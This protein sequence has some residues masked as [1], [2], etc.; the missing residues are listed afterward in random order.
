MQVQGLK[1][2]DEALKEFRP[3]T[4]RGVARRVLMKAGQPIAE[5]A[6]RLAPDDPATG[7]PYD[8]K[9]SITVSS[10]QIMGGARRR[11]REGA[12]EVTIYVGP[13]TDGYP[14]AMIQEFGA[15]HH[16]PQSYMRP[17]WDTHAEGALKSITTDMAVEIDKAAARAARKAARLAKAAGKGA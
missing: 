5:T 11:T 7:P 15:K 2:L 4:A 1:A 10:G 17:A 16:P 12:Q 14:Q 3:S 9:T 13:T 8:L 6:R